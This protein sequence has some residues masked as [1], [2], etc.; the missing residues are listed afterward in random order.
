MPDITYTITGYELCKARG[1]LDL[2]YDE[3]HH[4]DEYCD[5]HV[6]CPTCKRLWKDH[7]VIE[8]AVCR[9]G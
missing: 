1:R 8:M 5:E 6:E 4:S 7:A 2:T 3:E 9:N